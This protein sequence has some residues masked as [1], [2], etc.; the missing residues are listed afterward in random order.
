MSVAPEV[1]REFQAMYREANR[2][3]DEEMAPIRRALSQAQTVAAHRRR[4]RVAE[5]RRWRD[6]QPGAIRPMLRPAS[7]YDPRS[8]QMEARS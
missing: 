2:A 4:E 1:E 6:S 8:V 7:P 5:A 3:Y